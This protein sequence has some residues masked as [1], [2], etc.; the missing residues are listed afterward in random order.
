VRHREHELPH[1]R[2]ESNKTTTTTTKKK[3]KKKKIEAIRQP[4]ARN[5]SRA[6]EDAAMR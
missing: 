3:K 5:L 4:P 2:V 1:W 6:Q